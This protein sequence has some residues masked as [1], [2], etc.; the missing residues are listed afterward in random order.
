MKQQ[1]ILEKVRDLILEV[2]DIDREKITLNAT[3]RHD[4]KADSLASIEI[5]LALED[6]FKI[7]INE[8]LARQLVTVGDL[9]STIEAMPARQRINI[10]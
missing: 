5:I 9:I 2:V 4:L 1:A 10:D 8:D 7:E 6:C 3:L